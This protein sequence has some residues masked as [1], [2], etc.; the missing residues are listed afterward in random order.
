MATPDTSDE[1]R[2]AGALLARAEDDRRRSLQEAAVEAQR[3]QQEAENQIAHLRA[4]R[5]QVA[6]RRA[7]ERLDH[8]LSEIRQHQRAEEAR[9]V[10]GARARVMEAASQ[11]LAAIRNQPDYIAYLRH[12]LDEAI[13][14]LGTDTGFML[15][16]DER[17][18]ER[19]T[20]VLRRRDLKA[21]D[22][23]AGG[24]FLGG[25]QVSTRDGKMMIDHTFDARLFARLSSIHVHVARIFA[26]SD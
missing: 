13:K 6:G 19:V 11:Q 14:E 10:D 1:Q 15:T 23:V 8:Q 5:L 2:F 24:P 17:D 21:I 12:M 26:Q 22:V 20:D 7:R 18:R 9:L 3:L 4:E 16:I 25:F